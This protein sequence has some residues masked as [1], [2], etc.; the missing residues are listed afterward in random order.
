MNTASKSFDIQPS[1][2]LLGGV[3]PTPEKKNE[4]KQFESL[5][6]QSIDQALKNLKSITTKACW[7]Y[8]WGA[9]TRLPCPRGPYR[10]PC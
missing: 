7:I 6:N 4:R 10:H 1:S 3:K 8:W 9:K 5:M 2:P